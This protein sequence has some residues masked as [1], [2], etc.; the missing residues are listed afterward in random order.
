MSYIFSTR[1]FFNC[2]LLLLFSFQ[3]D[4]SY[5][6]FPNFPQYINELSKIKP[7][8]QGNPFYLY[9]QMHRNSEGKEI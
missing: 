6:L 5:L 2:F 3:N 9:F 4:E 8:H 1:L 7:H